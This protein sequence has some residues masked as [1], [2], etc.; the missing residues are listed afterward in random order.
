MIKVKSD[1]KRYGGFAAVNA[2]ANFHHL[3]TRINLA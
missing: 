2:G 1:S 3:D